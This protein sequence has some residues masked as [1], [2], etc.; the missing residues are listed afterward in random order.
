MCAVSMTRV[1]FAVSVRSRTLNSSGVLASVPWPI[2]SKAALASG[3]EKKYGDEE[4]DYVI[5]KRASSSSW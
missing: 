1:H 4:R 2:F 5:H 3:D